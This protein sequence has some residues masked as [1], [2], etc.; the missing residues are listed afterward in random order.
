MFVENTM[1]I[2]RIMKEMQIGKLELIFA[3]EKEQY[4]NIFEI[5]NNISEDSKSVYTFVRNCFLIKE[6]TKNCIIV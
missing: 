5:C 4:D 1:L 6:D 2:Q 3:K